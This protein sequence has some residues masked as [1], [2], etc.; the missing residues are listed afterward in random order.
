MLRWPALDVLVV[1]VMITLL[2]AGAW[3][4]REDV[5]VRLSRSLSGVVCPRRDQKNHEVHSLNLSL[6][7]NPHVVRKKQ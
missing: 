2:P 6:M 4:K 3:P 5:Q 1:L 7:R